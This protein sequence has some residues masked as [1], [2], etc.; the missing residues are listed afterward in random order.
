LPR[1]QTQEPA[2]Q[3]PPTRVEYHD[4]LNGRVPV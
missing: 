3:Q 2:P 1:R 4:L